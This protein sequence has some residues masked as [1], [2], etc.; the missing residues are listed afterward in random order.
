MQCAVCS[1]QSAVRGPL[2]AAPKS[3]GRA[4]CVRGARTMRTV[5]A[6][7][8]SGSRARGRV[9]AGC[10][11]ASASI[12]PS[13]PLPRPPTNGPPDTDTLA[14]FRRLP[15]RHLSPVVAP[16]CALPQLAAQPKEGQLLANAPNQSA[17]LHTNELHVGR[18]WPP[19][20]GCQWPD[21]CASASGAA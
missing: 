9:R 15:Q 2:R 6:R 17:I 16:I 8:I 21:N 5:R 10:P 19:S 7:R 20:T 14:A 12:Q 13:A 4:D 3:K 11:C 18:K 1:V